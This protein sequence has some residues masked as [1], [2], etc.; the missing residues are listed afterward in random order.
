VAFIDR[1]EP[2]EASAP[3]VEYLFARHLRADGVHRTET[4]VVHWTR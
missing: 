1:I 3:T 4:G 2:G